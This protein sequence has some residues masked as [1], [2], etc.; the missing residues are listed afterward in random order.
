MTEELVTV[1]LVGSATVMGGLKVRAISLANDLVPS[2]TEVVTT[3]QGTRDAYE[4]TLARLAAG[5]P[6]Y[7]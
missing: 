4:V 5:E 7:L 3:V 2:R 6:Q 1:Y